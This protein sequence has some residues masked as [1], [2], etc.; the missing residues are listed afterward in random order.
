MSA[1]PVNS[2]LLAAKTRLNSRMDPLIQR[3]PNV[4]VDPRTNKQKDTPMDQI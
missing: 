4:P 3:S 1:I 2:A